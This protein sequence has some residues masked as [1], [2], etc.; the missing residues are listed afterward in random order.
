MKKLL[1]SKFL[2]ILALSIIVLI[3]L[4]VGAF[5]LFDDSDATFVKDG[6]VLNPLSAKSEK[7]FFDEDTSYKENLNQM[8]VFDD[9]DKNE[10]K[11]LKDSFLHYM[12]GSLSFLK[13]GAILD[14]D[15]I[16]GMDAVKFYNI[17]N[18]SIINKSGN[19]YVIETTGDDIGLRNFIGRIS[20]NKYIVVGSLEA[21]IPGNEKNISGDYFE[22]VYTDEGIVN[23]ENKDIKFQV[24][25]Q[26][27]YIYA[28]D[29]VID[30]GNKKITKNNEDVMSITAITINGN[31]NIEIIPK[32]PDEEENG[33]GTGDDG[34]QG[35]DGNA[36]NQTPGNQD[37][38][39]TGNDGNTDGNND[40]QEVILDE[41]QVLLD[42]DKVSIDSSSITVAFRIINDRE[43]D[44][45][46]LKVTDLSTGRT[47]NEEVDIVDGKDIPVTLLTP[48]NKYLFTVINRR[49]Q[50]KYFQKIFET[51]DFGI[52]LEK[53][54]VTSS[55][56][57]Y[58]INLAN[59]GDISD[60]RL[61]LKKFDE[62][63]DINQLVTVDSYQLKDIIDMTKGEHDGIVFSGLESDTIYTA[64]LDNFSVASTNYNDIYNIALTSMTLKEKPTFGNMQKEITNDS[65]KLYIDSVNDPDNAI[66]K[67]TYKIYYA[68]DTEFLNPVKEIETTDA[69]PVEVAIGE[70]KDELKLGEKYVYKLAIEYFDNEKYIEEM[71]NGSINLSKGKDPY[72]V[73]KEGNDLSYNRFEALIYLYDN[74]CLIDIPGKCNISI[75]TPNDSIKVMVYELDAMGKETLLR[76][77][78]GDALQFN[79]DEETGAYMADLSVKNLSRETSYAIYV[80]AEQDGSS[81]QGFKPVIGTDENNIFTTK[82][83]ASFNALWDNKL[84][85]KDN[86]IETSVK[87][88]GIDKPD[89]VS[90]EETIDNIKAVIF[91]LYD[92]E[93]NPNSPELDEPKFIKASDPIYKTDDFSMLDK[94]YNNAYPIDLNDTFG[95]TR[96][97]LESRNEDG[98]LSPYY[99]IIMDAYYDYEMTEKNSVVINA[100]WNPYHINPEYRNVNPKL[101]LFATALKKN[102][103][104]ASYFDSSLSNGLVVGYELTTQ[105]EESKFTDNAWEIQDVNFYVYD[106]SRRKVSFYVLEDGK[107]NLYD[108]YSKH[109]G[110]EDFNKL[111]IYM[112][113]GTSGNG[114]MTRGNNY[115]VGYE[116]IYK[117]NDQTYPY[118]SNDNVNVPAGSGFYKSIDELVPEKDKALK[119]KP[120]L[121]YA[122]IWE[123]T[124]DGKVTYKY[125]ITDI[126]NAIAKE[127]NNKYIYYSINDGD[128]EQLEFSNPTT[129]KGGGLIDTNI[130]VYEGEFT[131]SG[132]NNQDAY[133]LFYHLLLH[134]SEG[135]KED[136]IGIE[137]RLFDGYYDSKDY[138]FKFEI[139]P[140][141]TNLDTV[142]SNKVTVK[143]L[144]DDELLSRVLSYKIKFSD[145]SHDFTEEIYQL[146]MCLDAAPGDIPRCYVLDYTDDKLKDMKTTGNTANEITVSVEAIYD[147]GLTGYGYK[148]KVDNAEAEKDYPYMIMQEN[149]E[150]D[151]ECKYRIINN[152]VSRWS[153]ANYPSGYYRFELVERNDT[154]T[155]FYYTKMYKP[156]KDKVNGD[157]YGPYELI[158]NSSGLGVDA[159][160]INPKMVSDKLMSSDPGK[161]KFSF[162][163]VTPTI[164]INDNETISLINGAIVNI[165]LS[166]A[167]LEDI[168][169]KK[170]GNNCN[171]GNGDRYLYLDVW[172]N[173]NDV[174]DNTKT[175]IKTVEVLLDNAQNNVNRS[176]ITKIDD[177]VN[178]S[179]DH[180]YYYT[181]YTYVNNEGNKK[182]TRVLNEGSGEKA[183]VYQ[184][185]T[186]K[187]LDIF[188]ENKLK[189]NIIPNDKGEYNDKLL[190]TD[191]TLNKYSKDFDIP[192]NFKLTYVLCDIDE[193]CDLNNNIIK[194]QINTEDEF[195][196]VTNGT[197]TVSINDLVDISDDIINKKIEFGK[198]YN[199]KFYVT[200]D[201]FNENKEVV[202]KTFEICEKTVLGDQT[203]HDI[204][205]S[206]VRRR[207]DYVDGDY[208]I[209]LNIELDDVDRLLVDGNYYVQ[210]TDQDGN[211][212]GNLKL[213]QDGNYIV[214][215][216]SDGD[217]KYD[218]Y[219]IK[220][221]DNQ[222]IR[223]GGLN[224]DTLYTVKVL[225]Y[226]YI[227]DTLTPIVS[228]ENGEGHRVYSSNNLGVAFGD[229][230]LYTFAESTEEN[231]IIANFGYGSNLK[232][233]ENTV[234][235]SVTYTIKRDGANVPPKS[236]T[237]IIPD[238]IG[239][240]RYS[241]YNNLIMKFKIDEDLIKINQGDQYI[242]TTSYEVYDSANDRYETIDFTTYPSLSGKVFKY[243]QSN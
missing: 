152:G 59:D 13:N 41:L 179:H 10:V 14:L 82:K 2:F 221:L 70:G 139:N 37:G 170:N 73:I 162:S 112:G 117:E 63:K 135:I 119:D 95:L 240:D 47:V 158:L 220:Y 200:Y 159:G 35:N 202:D 185:N 180:T 199:I 131:L 233:N 66:D 226:S 223:I 213:Q 154:I 100:K 167:F 214:V 141:L 45:L 88:E 146:N 60:A 136:S 4:G 110:D 127:D 7:Y 173:E 52:S 218:K 181:I 228:G 222:T 69:L 169:V 107:L 32:A 87:L 89:V 54:Y 157:K 106:D 206:T 241:G 25:A 133:S 83:L 120:T 242:F 232:E 64:V 190:S 231:T 156:I 98:L 27:S 188:D 97:Y 61:T 85:S 101:D 44:N 178:L 38:N 78:T 11:V 91:K 77:Y 51:S 174:N 183:I 235:K 145:G 151:K 143:I 204:Q 128:N 113:Y 43:D 65:F 138:N 124:K 28:G 36:N 39:G 201:S 198:D 230:V 8:V 58:K 229:S 12:D 171:T 5:Y 50:N 49:D 130:P 86:P 147:N 205:F 195:T 75:D 140:N 55:Q 182:K 184:I 18:K 166:G 191:I 31:E 196:T 42:P 9:V 30:L 67:Y 108:K 109:Y 207:A 1:D 210:L 165:H 211:L 132:L 16:Q 186:K 125:K 238:E 121:K 26:G 79:L 56:I 102:S 84:G 123:T 155:G 57:G 34:N 192:F 53:S 227:D 19:G 239:F 116:I 93:Y 99:T 134:N 187:L 161:N 3:I 217:D 118:P 142:V 224:A 160:A 234:I 176:Y 148:D 153:A 150:K 80:V 103:A 104:N 237:L 24:A 177:I 22:I 71:R 21:K 172:E 149:C 208:I 23:I 105:I 197:D 137:N 48:E 114:I 243:N 203:L 193:Q 76:E 68:S 168:C 72:V 74:D 96:D 163:S 175:P 209:E 219:P 115:Y 215:A 164:R 122:Y 15:S 6:Y 194:K 17:T 111:E 92:G 20:D 29:T 33:N 40:K 94:F 212:K 189:V 236:K 144:A 46:V 126:D 225:A 90:P 81:T 216:T 62:S 129:V